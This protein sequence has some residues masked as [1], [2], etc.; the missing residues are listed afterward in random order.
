[1]SSDTDKSDRSGT[2]N[3]SNTMF[4]LD[5]LPSYLIKPQPQNP[6]ISFP[7]FHNCFLPLHSPTNSV[8]FLCKHSNRFSKQE[9]THNW[10]GL[11][12]IRGNKLLKDLSTWGI[13]GSSNYFVQVHNQTQLLSAIR[14]TLDLLFL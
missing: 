4:I 10:D 7:L 6:S 3:P 13:G 8:S 11:N 14:F 2:R 9:Q 5:S 1:M 12:F